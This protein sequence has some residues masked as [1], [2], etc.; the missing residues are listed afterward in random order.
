MP[1]FLILHPAF[2]GEPT[3]MQSES[4]Y[5]KFLIYQVY[6]MYLVKHNY[7]MYMMKFKNFP[8]IGVL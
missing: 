8:V 1:N 3:L 2:L 7:T 6:Q 5:Y 4:I